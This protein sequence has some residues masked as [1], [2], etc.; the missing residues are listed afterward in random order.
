MF[1]SRKEGAQEMRCLFERLHSRQSR[2]DWEKNQDIYAL[3]RASFRMLSDFS[4]DEAD[5][6]QAECLAIARQLPLSR[7]KAYL[8]FLCCTGNRVLGLDELVQLIQECVQYFSDLGDRWGKALSLLL[9]GDALNFNG[10]LLEQARNSYHSSLELFGG[11]NNRWGQAL[12]FHGLAIVEKKAGNLPLAYELNAQSLELYE[13]L[14]NVERSIPVRHFQAELA[15]AMG[16][17]ALA[18]DLYQVNLEYFSRV[19]N[20]A[21]QDFYARLVNQMEHPV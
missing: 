18:R 11:L 12:C 2:P 3:A 7:E 16:Q 4:S 6:I 9:L 19:G 15:C 20:Q 14:Q 1:G 5:Q 13:H 10:E 8:H 17:A 21:A